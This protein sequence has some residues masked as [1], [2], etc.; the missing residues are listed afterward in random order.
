MRVLIILLFIPFIGF[1]QAPNQFKYQSIARDLAGSVLNTVPIGLRISVRDLSPTGTI[2]FQETHSLTT[3]QF[4]LFT[5]SIGGGTPVTG[6]I[7]LVDW[8][9]GAK[10]V[11]IEADLSGGTAY[12]PFGTTELLSVPYAIYAN[13][14]G[15]P[16]LPNGT[17]LG[18]TSLHDVEIV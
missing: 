16:I 4:G 15:I 13:T 3:N 8:G 9:N 12:D 2:V 7:A 1:S 18:N 14:A 10:Y 5:L 17:D 6:T 11:E